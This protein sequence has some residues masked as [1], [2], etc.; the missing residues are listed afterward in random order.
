MPLSDSTSSPLTVLRLDTGWKCLL[1]AGNLVGLDRPNN[2]F[3]CKLVK[4]VFHRTKVRSEVER[5]WGKEGF[6]ETERRREK[7]RV[8]LLGR[9]LEG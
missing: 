9:D 2:L 5:W 6:G 7:G 3:D 8:L 1:E 4:S